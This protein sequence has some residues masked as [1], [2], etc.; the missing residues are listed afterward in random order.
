MKTYTE[1]KIPDFEVKDDNQNSFYNQLDTILQ[2]YNFQSKVGMEL[3]HVTNTRREVKGKYF[4]RL[5]RELYSDL[6]DLFEK[7]NHLNNEGS[8]DFSLTLDEEVFVDI[9]SRRVQR[10]SISTPP[11]TPPKRS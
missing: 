11:P 9:I 3:M 2:K 4:N 6:H 5:K 7:F 8:S 10:E 1:T